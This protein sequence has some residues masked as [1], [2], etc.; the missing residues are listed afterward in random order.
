MKSSI[1]AQRQF[2]LWAPVVL[3]AALL[4]VL[5]SYT[6]PFPWF[7]KTQ[8][9]HVDWL[10]HVVEYAVFGALV[11]RAL[12]AQSFFR[13]SSGKLFIA[14]VMIGVLYGTSDEFHQRYV[15]H[16]DSSLYDGVADTVGA[17]LGTWIW[18]KKPRKENA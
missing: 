12:S 3:Y 17:A 1:R 13:R 4:Y 2:A 14:T 9:I 7:Q 8:K 6:F 11:C 5:S 16:R 15:P 18:L 10:A